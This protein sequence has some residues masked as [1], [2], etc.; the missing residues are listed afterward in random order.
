[1]GWALFPPAFLVLDRGGETESQSGGTSGFSTYVR[2]C[3]TGKPLPSGLR[4]V[5]IR[6]RGSFLSPFMEYWG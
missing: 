1:M 4:P 2:P 6:N 3:G 5:G